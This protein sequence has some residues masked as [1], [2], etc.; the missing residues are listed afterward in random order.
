[1]NQAATGA[2]KR[3]VLERVTDCG[4]L[5]RATFHSSWATA[6]DCWHV[7]LTGERSHGGGVVVRYP[8]GAMEADW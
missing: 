2:I 5:A 8:D 6:T 3:V 1:M 4:A 7:R